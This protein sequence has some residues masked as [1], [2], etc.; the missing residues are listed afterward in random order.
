MAS[1]MKMKDLN[2][3]ANTTIIMKKAFFLAKSL[4]SFE[5]RSCHLQDPKLVQIHLMCN[6]V[7]ISVTF[8]QI[9][10]SFFGREIRTTN[11]LKYALFMLQLK[12][13]QNTRKIIPYKIKIHGQTHLLY[14]LN[15]A[16]S[17]YF[18][19][20]SK[21]KIKDDETILIKNQKVKK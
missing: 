21:I 11:I 8:Y 9:Y 5:L 12:I 16:K 1:T 2:F 19:L 14:Q 17:Y 4:Q 15:T 6:T 7:R 13:V 18:N 10:F 20:D 3:F